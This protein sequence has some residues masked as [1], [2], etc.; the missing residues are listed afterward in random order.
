MGIRSGALGTKV[1]IVRRM[2]YIPNLAGQASLLSRGLVL[3][4]MA[5]MRKKSVDTNVGWKTAAFL[6]H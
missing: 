4:A 5:E 1:I 3:V 6:T 2:K